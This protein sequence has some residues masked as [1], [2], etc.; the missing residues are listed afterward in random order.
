MPS[1][2]LELSLSRC[3][4][5]CLPLCCS[6]IFLSPFLPLSSAPFPSHHPSAAL[7]PLPLY[8]SICLSLSL[9]LSVLVS[10]P[11]FY[12]FA[13]CDVLLAYC[14]IFCHLTCLSVCLSVCLSSYLTHAHERKHTHTHVNTPPY[15][16]SLPPVCFLNSKREPMHRRTSGWRLLQQQQGVL[17]VHRGTIRTCIEKY[18][19]KNTELR[20]RHS[21][22]FFR[23]NC[24][25]KTEIS[26]VSH[27][28]EVLSSPEVRFV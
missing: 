6:L 19:R 5:L 13:V 12:K 26:L 27:A 15:I 1:L 2:A 7:P 21:V 24:L 11:L 23:Q 22:E 14:F 28:T 18:N 4:S 17:R 25:Q 10:F 9:S 3:I 16:I 20:S 8:H